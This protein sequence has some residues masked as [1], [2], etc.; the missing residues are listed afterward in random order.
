MCLCSCLNSVLRFSFY[1]WLLFIL[2]HLQTTVNLHFVSEFTSRGPNITV[3]NKQP[4]HLDII[5]SET[6]SLTN[7]IVYISC[8]DLFLLNDWVI[9]SLISLTYCIDNALTTTR[10]NPFMSSW[11]NFFFFNW[12][13]VSD[14][15]FDLWSSLN[16]CMNI[17]SKFNFYFWNKK[18]TDTESDFY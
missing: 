12:G 6:F 14:I 17:E 3:H 8:N 13:L 7:N 10:Q 2:H 9:P 15:T 1:P 18:Q 16:L 11:Y 5:S 4:P